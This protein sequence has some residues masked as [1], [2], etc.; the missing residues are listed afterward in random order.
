M[1]P[2]NSKLQRET[3]SSLQTPKYWNP[4]GFLKPKYETDYSKPQNANKRFA[5]S[6]A[7]Q[8][9]K[10]FGH[11][12][13]NSMNDANLKTHLKSNSH[14][15]SPQ[16]T[17]AS[18]EIIRPNI[19]RQN[20]S[21]KIPKSDLKAAK[22]QPEQ[23]TTLVSPTHSESSSTFSRQISGSS[24]Q[25]RNNLGHHTRYRSSDTKIEENLEYSYFPKSPPKTESKEDLIDTNPHEKEII[26]KSI[27]KIITD[28]KKLEAEV[29]NLREQREV[30]RMK[31]IQE[32]HKNKQLEHELDVT[33]N[34]LH[35]ALATVNEYKE[36][37]EQY[38][39]KKNVAISNLTSI[40]KE[41]KFDSE[42]DQIQDEMEQMRHEVQALR[43][44]I[45]LVEGKPPLL[46]ERVSSATSQ[47][48][49]KLLGGF[50][51]SATFGKEA[52]RGKDMKPEEES[53][54]VIE[55][56]VSEEEATPRF[57]LD[58]K[59]SNQ[60]HQLEYHPLKTETQS[61]RKKP[62]QIAGSEKRSQSH[63]QKLRKGISDTEY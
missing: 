32:E 1:I 13:S 36:L 5:D 60:Q 10:T 55:A 53:S 21:E 51:Y 16:P 57:E 43:R 37:F 14:V 22:K 50:G 31:R 39:L 6:H 30:E 3:S 38:F 17:L 41:Q 20:F 56:I 4:V 24:S 54:E 12:F 19:P 2:D 7:S 35:Q 45:A 63:N 23:P 29:K 52:G 62:L 44:K 9:N 25:R 34:K 18:S 33:H 8:M 28:R 61:K 47:L 15:F 11:I 26:Y 40:V 48:H 42:E 49:K 27:D 58:Y 46:N 59:S